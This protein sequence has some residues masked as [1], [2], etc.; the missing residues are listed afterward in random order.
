MKKT[1]T[2]LIVDD[3]PE[4]GIMLKIML[5][6]KGFSVIILNNAEKLNETLGTHTIDVIILDMLIAGLKGSEIA[7]IL[8]NNPTTS[9][10]PMRIESGALL[11]SRKRAR[12]DRVASCECHLGDFRW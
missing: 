10:Y 2:I 11:T 6:H 5:E 12:D 3:D 4:I 8:K 1:F 7:A 9:Q